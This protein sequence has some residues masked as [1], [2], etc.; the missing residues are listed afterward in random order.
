MEVAETEEN[1]LDL[2]IVVF[3]LIFREESESSLHVL[4]ESLWRLVSELNASLKKTNWDV[5]TWIRRKEESETWISLILSEQIKFL[6]KIFQEEWHEMNVLEHD[7]V[8]LFVTD[9]KLVHGNDILSL[10]E[11]NGVKTL[12]DINSILL[13]KLLDIL[14]W[15]GSWRKDE[16]DWSIGG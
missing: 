11:G 2:D 4:F 5:L 3:E 10:T 16:V 13:G 15:I 1:C 9:L 6:L 12:V 7:P 14:N 8:S